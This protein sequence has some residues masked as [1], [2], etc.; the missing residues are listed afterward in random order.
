MAYL[1]LY[2]MI[3]IQIMGQEALISFGYWQIYV[4]AISCQLGKTE[5]ENTQNNQ[6]FATFNIISPQGQRSRS[7][8]KSYMT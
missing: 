6:F 1:V 3:N 7:Q 8:L 4:I 2:N 5:E